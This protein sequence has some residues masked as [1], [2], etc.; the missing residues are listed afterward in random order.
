MAELRTPLL[1]KW[2]QSKAGLL[3][4]PISPLLLLSL[5]Y[6]VQYC[7]VHSGEWWNKEGRRVFIGN[8]TKTANGNFFMEENRDYFHAS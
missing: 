7:T 4:K 5:H 3:T 1:R 8:D 6:Y 2:Q